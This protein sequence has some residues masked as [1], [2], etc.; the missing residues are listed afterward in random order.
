MCSAP[1]TICASE[2]FDLACTAENLYV[3]FLKIKKRRCLYWAVSYELVNGVFV[4]VDTFGLCTTGYF[5]ELLAW[6]SRAEPSQKQSTERRLFRPEAA[7]PCQAGGGPSD[8]LPRLSAQVLSLSLRQLPSPI[9]TS[10]FFG[11]RPS[12]N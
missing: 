6:L 2:P 1:A 8:A 10:S 12:P 7:A 5:R 3:T 4:P 11:R 9:Q